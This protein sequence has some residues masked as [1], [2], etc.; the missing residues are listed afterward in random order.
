MEK[1]LVDK[2]ILEKHHRIIGGL[3]VLERMAKGAE[4]MPGDR[5]TNALIDTACVALQKAVVS[6]WEYAL[7]RDA[8][9]AE[10]SRDG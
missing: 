10:G 3:Q 5:G 9:S 8:D 1:R 4:C 7:E 2:D 6:A